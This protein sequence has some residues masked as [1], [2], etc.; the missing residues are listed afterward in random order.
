MTANKFYEQRFNYGGEIRTV[1]SVVKEW[2]EKK[3][4]QNL[5]DAYLMGL[6]NNHFPLKTK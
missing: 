6:A 5:I 3:I 1:G 2:Q 4:A